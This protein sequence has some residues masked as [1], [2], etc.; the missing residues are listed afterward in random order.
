[1]QEKRA[2]P[3]L[4]NLQFL[5]L[6][7]LRLREQPGRVLREALAEYGVRR[8]APAFY[9]LMSRLESAGLVV[10]RYEQIT[11]GD[12]AVTE[13]WYRITTDGARQWQRAQTFYSEVGRLASKLRWS[14]A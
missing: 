14:N 3:A 2:L 7:V 10:G 4:T 11:V 9:Q 6:G 12:Q 1:M 5:V 8:T 13:R